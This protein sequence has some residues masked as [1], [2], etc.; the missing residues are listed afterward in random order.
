M[1]WIKVMVISANMKD[2]SVILFELV[3]MTGLFVL[4][5][6]TL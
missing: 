2:L 3:W 4:S 6:G 1:I 5:L